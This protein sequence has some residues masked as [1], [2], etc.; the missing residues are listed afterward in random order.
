MALLTTFEIIL[1]LP[2]D[3]KWIKSLNVRTLE[4]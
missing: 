4:K 2:N 1:N 3:E